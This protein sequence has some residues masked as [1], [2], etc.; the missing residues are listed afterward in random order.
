M[1]HGGRLLTLV[2]PPGVGKTTLSLA[3]AT[4]VQQHYADGA[5][6]PAGCD[7]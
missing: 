5:L 1:G 6:Y 2:G 3:V 7:Q 4:Q